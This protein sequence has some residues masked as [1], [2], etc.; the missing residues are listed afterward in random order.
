MSAIEALVSKLSDSE[1]IDEFTPRGVAVC[2]FVFISIQHL[3]HLILV[4]TDAGT[5][6]PAQQLL[7]NFPYKHSA[8]ANVVVLFFTV[9]SGE[10]SLCTSVKLYHW[11]GLVLS[12]TP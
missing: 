5:H 3:E 4:S 11:L 9:L 1:E 12:D 8:K 6:R 7:Q 2:S 10:Y